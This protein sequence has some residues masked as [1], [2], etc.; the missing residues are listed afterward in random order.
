MAGGGSE[1]TMR[2][3]FF[4]RQSQRNGRG[5]LEAG[6]ARKVGYRQQQIRVGQ[7]VT[8]LPCQRYL[9][10]RHLRLPSRSAVTFVYSRVSFVVSV[11]SPR[12]GVP[13]RSCPTDASARFR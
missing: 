9:K 8:G 2:R 1:R 10:V 13:Y 5:H 7:G 11:V 6:P 4:W 12:L 3:V